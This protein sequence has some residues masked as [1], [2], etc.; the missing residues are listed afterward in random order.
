[1]L[2]KENILEKLNQF[3]NMQYFSKAI[4][5]NPIKKN[6]TLPKKVDIKKI[7]L[8]NKICYQFAY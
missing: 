2:T 1:M 4:I 8:K 5:S 6:E 7:M 3:I